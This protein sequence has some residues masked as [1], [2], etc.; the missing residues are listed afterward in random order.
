MMGS[1]KFTLGTEEFSKQFWSKVDKSAGPKACWRWLG[2]LQKTRGFYGICWHDGRHDKA[3][4]VAWL[5]VHGSIPD[6]LCVIHGCDHGWC[7]N[8]DHLS[9]GTVT[10]NNLDAQRKGRVGGR[11]RSVTLPPPA[12]PSLIAPEPSL[13]DK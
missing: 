1:P 5:L 10:R 8:P 4:R 13:S 3:H 11:K 7:V 12:Q 9:V 6:N 2:G